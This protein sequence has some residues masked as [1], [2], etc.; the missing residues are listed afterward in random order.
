MSNTDFDSNPNKSARV[1]Q[2]SRTSG[3]GSGNDNE[4][5][6]GQ[7]IVL[8]PAPSSVGSEKTRLFEN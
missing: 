7:P 4:V 5:N 3:M 6:N 1:T 8:G 2:P